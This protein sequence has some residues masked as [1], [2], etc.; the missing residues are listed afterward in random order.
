MLIFSHLPA[1]GGGSAIPT[2]SGLHPPGV[3]KEKLSHGQAQGRAV[4]LLNFWPFSRS[5]GRKSPETTVMGRVSIACTRRAR[6]SCHPS[7]SGCLPTLLQPQ[8]TLN[9]NS[10]DIST[11]RHLPPPHACIGVSC[12]SLGAGPAPSLELQDPRDE[13]APLLLVLSCRLGSAP[14]WASCPCLPCCPASE[15]NQS[16]TRLTAG[17]HGSH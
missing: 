12:S 7:L 8:Q 4:L 17:M 6:W 14:G 3:A 9:G 2:L 11:S 1:S 13:P 10:R 15:K 5:R 16:S